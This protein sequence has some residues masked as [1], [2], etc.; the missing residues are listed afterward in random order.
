MKTNHVT[1]YT[2]SL[3]EFR[4]LCHILTILD[5]IEFDFENYVSDSEYIE[6]ESFISEVVT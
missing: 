2:L 5:S 6:I 4:V 3:A 1:T